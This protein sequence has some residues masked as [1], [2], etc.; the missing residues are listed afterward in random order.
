MSDGDGTDLTQRTRARALLAEAC[1]QYAD[2]Y[3]ATAGAIVTGY[4]VVM[5]VSHAGG[6]RH[7]VWATGDG[8]IPTGDDSAWLYEWQAE[9]LLRQ[10]LHDI[11]RG[12]VSRS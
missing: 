6:K 11:R 12:N 4:V 9:G 8:G 7:V 10:V 3:E 2:T 5:E 1:A